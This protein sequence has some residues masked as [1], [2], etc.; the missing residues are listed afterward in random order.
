MMGAFVHLSECVYSCFSFVVTIDADLLSLFRKCH[1]ILD[2]CLHCLNFHMASTDVEEL[3]IHQN[4]K[5]RVTSYKAIHTHSAF[6]DMIKKEELKFMCKQWL[7]YILF[8]NF[9][10]LQI[11]KC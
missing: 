6:S 1:Y 2:Q 5:P 10:I 3:A 7:Q 11:I 8:N 9:T 4:I